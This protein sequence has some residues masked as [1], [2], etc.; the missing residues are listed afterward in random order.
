QM[1]LVRGHAGRRR[2]GACARLADVTPRARDPVAAA[3][4]V[5]LG[6][7][8]ARARRG[9]TGPGV[10][11][12]IRRAA[13]HRARSGAN[14][15]LDGVRLRAGV[16][17]V[18]RRAVRTRAVGR[19]I[20]RRAVTALRRV[21]LPRGG[22]AHLG[23]LGVGRTAG[24][25][26]RAQLGH[27]ADAGRIAA[28]DGRRLEGVGRAGIVRPVTTLLDIARTGRRTADVGRL[29]H[30]RRT[31]R[32]GA[33]AGLRRVAETRGG[34]TRGARGLEPIRRARVVRAV[35]A[36]IGVAWARCRAA[37]VDLLRIVGAAG[38]RA[39]AGLR[40][41]TDAG[42]RATLDARGLEAVRRARIVRAV[43]ALVD[44]ARTRCRTADVRVLLHVGGTRDVGAR[45]GLRRVTHAGGRP[46]GGG[47]G[48]EAV[49]RA[50]IV[51]P[52]AALLH[53]ARTRRRTADAR[54]LLVGGARGTRAGAGLGRVADARGGATLRARALEPVRRTG[55]ERPVAP[56]LD[57]AGA[58]RGPAH[59]GGR[60]ELAVGRAAV[61][62]QLV[63]VV[64]VLARVDDAVAAARAHDRGI[65]DPGD[66]VVQLHHVVVADAALGTAHA[67]DDLGVAVE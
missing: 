11:A 19:A 15:R 60:L 53:V 6:R 63:A 4:A 36:L 44:V 9:V 48:L 1:T 41:V 21:T 67:G 65:D 43:A 30:V 52:V 28:R 27:V 49:R 26:S 13:P 23:L 64:A 59:R 46:A 33:G 12:L 45:A 8:G 29:L 61:A 18:A 58:G 20:V 54:L 56:L 3:G 7:V 57:V 38:T 40:R 35:A 2:T 32:V 14:A 10:V 24:A 42:R 51:R 47:G 31:G 34:A 22:A 62:V 37:D 16:P 17:V 66:G 50:V 39:G 25:R 55:V 5:V